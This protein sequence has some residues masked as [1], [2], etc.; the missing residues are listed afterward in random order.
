MYPDDLVC[1]EDEPVSFETSN[2]R[3]ESSSTF[4]TIGATFGHH[5]SYVLNSC[6]TVHG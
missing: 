5:K 2:G 1:H 6:P 4:N 3:I